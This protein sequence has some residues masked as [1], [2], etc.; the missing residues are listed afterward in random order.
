[1]KLIN[2]GKVR[3]IYEFTDIT[4]LN[5][6]VEYSSPNYLVED[7]FVLESGTNAVI[8]T[9]FDDS[10]LDKVKLAIQKKENVDSLLDKMFFRYERQSK[11][12]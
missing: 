6:G 2:R 11:I 5:K 3:D 12:T 1:M 7:R 8:G 9:L 4:R 10:E